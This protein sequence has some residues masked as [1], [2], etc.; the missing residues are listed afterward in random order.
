MI[1]RE[2]DI[3]RLQGRGGEKTSLGGG[4]EALRRTQD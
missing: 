4:R 2:E 1:R 3:K